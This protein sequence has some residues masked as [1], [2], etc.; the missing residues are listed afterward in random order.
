[1]VQSD[2]RKNIPN[3]FKRYRYLQLTTVLTKIANSFIKNFDRGRPKNV[4]TGIDS[5]KK[6][7]KDSLN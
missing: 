2:F 6:A 5:S 1:L 7:V 3:A 4:P